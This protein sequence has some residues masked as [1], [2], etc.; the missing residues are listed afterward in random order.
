MRFEANRGRHIRLA[1][2]VVGNDGSLDSKLQF[3]FGGTVQLLVNR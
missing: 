3:G 1:R 2:D